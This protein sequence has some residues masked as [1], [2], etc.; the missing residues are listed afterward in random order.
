MMRNDFVR[1]VILLMCLFGAPAGL[2]TAQKPSGPSDTVRAEIH[3]RLKAF[4][5]NL[6]R[7]N[8]EALTADILAAK[9]VAHRPAPD[10]LLA[11]ANSPR[12]VSCS[13]S[14]GPAIEQAS[15]FVKGDWAEASVP[16]C[17]ATQ[18]GS[19]RFRFIHFEA[20]WRLVYI[21]LFE[22]PVIVSADR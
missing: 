7:K 6:A 8:W 11:A 1:C 10:G 2:A 13:T 14:R 4:Y 15:I 9:V 18:A 20:R 21:E 5:F 16:H 19:D 12:A 22:E 3:T 17:V